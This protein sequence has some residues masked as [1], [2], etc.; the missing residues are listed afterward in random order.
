MNTLLLMAATSFFQCEARIPWPGVTFLGQGVTETQARNEALK[1]CHV[2]GH[3]FC[4][5][6]SCEELK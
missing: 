3:T 5:I 4:F 6:S 1:S 2:A